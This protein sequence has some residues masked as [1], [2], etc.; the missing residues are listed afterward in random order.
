MDLGLPAG[1]DGPEESFQKCLGQI[2]SAGKKYN[3]PM[4]TFT[5]GPGHVAQKL[6]E[7]F[8]AF[9]VGNDAFAIGIGGRMTLKQ[10]YDEVEEWKNDGCKV[11]RRA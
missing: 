4:L 6:K 8:S 5:A 1:M 2:L 11:T 3:R 7:G 9:V 10:S